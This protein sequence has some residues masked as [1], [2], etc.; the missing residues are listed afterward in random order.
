M[1]T[2]AELTREIKRLRSV[3][4][5][6][7]SRIDRAIQK[8]K[9]PKSASGTY[10]YDIVEFQRRPAN[11]KTSA[12]YGKLYGKGVKKAQLEATLRSLQKLTTQETATQA[13]IRNRLK[14][15]DDNAEFV[16]NTYAGFDED[17]IAVMT[18]NQKSK[19]FQFAKIIQEELGYDSDT[20]FSNITDT[21]RDRNKKAS[22]MFLEYEKAAEADKKAKDKGI[23]LGDNTY[24]N[25]FYKKYGFE[26]QNTEEKPKPKPK[27]KKR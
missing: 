24:V 4:E 26:K 5:A 16:L 21:L 25:R 18:R 12:L 1:A 22:E 11:R 10:F 23:D 17:E 9:L 7:F 27:R 3:A 2:R 20:A 8:G 13:G 15:L 6:Q 19:F 14:E